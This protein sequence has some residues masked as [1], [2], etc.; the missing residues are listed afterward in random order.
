MRPMQ[1]FYSIR[2]LTVLSIA[3]AALPPGFEDEL[4]CPVGNCL[5][6]N[7]SHMRGW[8]GPQTEYYVCVPE[9][10]RTGNSNR[11]KGWGELVDVRIKEAIIES[12][13]VL[14]KKCPVSCDT[15]PL[16]KGIIGHTNGLFIKALL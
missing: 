3:K 11:P 15:H 5:K 16:I 4:Y 10:G 1:L 12:G 6:V 7:P 9:C 14:A 8:S 2:I 13:W